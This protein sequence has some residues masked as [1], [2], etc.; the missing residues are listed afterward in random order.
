MSTPPT[1]QDNLPHCLYKL[2]R[3]CTNIGRAFAAIGSRGCELLR[4]L[5]GASNPAGDR[6]FSCCSQC[7]QSQPQLFEGKG[8][9]G[10]TIGGVGSKWH[11]TQ[12]CGGGEGGRGVIKGEERRAQGSCAK[13]VRQVQ[14]RLS[15]LSKLGSSDMIGS[16]PFNRRP[17][18]SEI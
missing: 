11:S 4:N 2:T 3:H 17:G 15:G 16:A 14:K 7:H 10:N 13:R 5:R 18:R 12:F 9:P 8:K 1:W 6:A